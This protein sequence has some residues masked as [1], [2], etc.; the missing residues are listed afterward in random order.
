MKTERRGKGER[1][2]GRNEIH[3]LH[4]VGARPNF[5]KV[6]PVMRALERY[7][8][9]RQSL[10]HTG[11]HYD[12][13]MSRIFFSDL[14]LPA[15]TV[16]LKV[17]SGSH[18]RQTSEIMV[19]LESEIVKRK[20]D[21]V[22]AYGDVNSTVAAA[23]VCSKLGV[24]FGHVEAG[25]RSF[26]RS[27]P[28]EIN[29]LLTDQISDFLFT[30][31]LDGNKN[32][33]REGVSKEKIY[34][35][36]NVMIDTLVRLLPKARAR[37]RE[38]GFFPDITGENLERYG[39]V[40]L[41]RPSNVDEMGLLSSIMRSLN[42]ISRSLP[43]VFPVHPRTRKQFESLRF[44]QSQQLY[45]S[46]PLSYVDFLALQ[47]RATLVITD[48]GGIQEETTYLGVPCLTLRKNTERPVTVTKGTNILVG[49]D[50]ENL[51]AAVEKILKN[52]HKKRNIPALWDG[53]ASERI[54]KTIIRSRL[55]ARR[56][57]CCS[58]QTA[59]W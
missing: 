38:P 29:R 59:Q 13:N 17:G 35:V 40:T 34:F 49:Q 52:P 21:L 48:S 2:I 50:M 58:S 6:A 22:L 53:K 4:V 26:D 33:L 44:K 8:A 32:L 3:I 43:L 31:S 56:D 46:A 12:D 7:S 15:P 30:P 10:V 47:C 9:T 14:G 39:L 18:A 57:M 27:M 11:Q 55:F 42:K 16:N 45:F 23:L 37:W 51:L 28:E 1:R 41:H 20:P 54:A 25:L 5:M 36:G 24:L 19:R